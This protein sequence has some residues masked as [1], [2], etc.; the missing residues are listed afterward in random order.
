MSDPIVPSSTQPTTLSA[1][2]GKYFLSFEV[3]EMC[4]AIADEI[5][6]DKGLVPSIVAEVYR[7][8]S[9]ESSVDVYVENLRSLTK[10]NEST[11]EKF[12]SQI[13]DRI[14]APVAENVE[15]LSSSIEK[16]RSVDSIS[17]KIP[18]TLT[19]KDQTE[20]SATKT[21]APNTDVEQM[22]STICSDTFLS[23]VDPTLHNRCK[24]IVESRVRDVR[25]GDQTRGKLEAAVSAGG[26]GVMGRALADMMQTIEQAVDVVKK[27]N[28]EKNTRT[29]QSKQE[30]KL[31]IATLTEDLKKKEEQ[32]LSKR[33]VQMTG[34]MP[35]ESVAPVAPS[36][37]RTSAAISVSDQMQKQEQKIDPEK[38][39]KVIEASTQKIPVTRPA[40]DPKP[41]VQ[42]VHSSKR[43]S[44]PVDELQAM[45]LTDFRRLSSEPAQAAQR[46]HDMIDLLEEQ[47]YGKRVAG[48]HAF[49]TSALEQLYLSITQDA[50]LGGKG[51]DDILA[52]ESAQGMK[53]AEYQA[54]MKLNEVIRF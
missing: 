19:Q 35:T 51:V 40:L 34:K 39:R 10:L 1:E 4:D 33:Y 31:V 25:D 6:F 42:D 11:F 54:L 15:G 38:V 43:L 26:L 8:A 9:G 44:G 17:V 28:A 14:L 24:Q 36:L 30:Q 23:S 12:L 46:I 13:V 52:T 32:V 16:L 41:R 49:R 7:L 48:I 37:A 18:D 3:F 2:M 5:G 50:L 29:L 53:K 21:F 22:I 45:T 47:G 20:V 27:Q